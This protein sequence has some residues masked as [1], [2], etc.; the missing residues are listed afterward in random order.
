MAAVVKGFSKQPKYPW[1]RW[2]DGRVRLAKGGVDFT[3]SPEAFKW[4]LNSRARRD[5]TKVR[6]SI[7]NGDVEFQFTRKS[8]KHR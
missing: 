5:G 6:T 7:V 2:T 1:L 3:I 8:R 4:T